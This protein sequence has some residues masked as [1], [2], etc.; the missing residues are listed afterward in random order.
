LANDVTLF[1]THQANMSTQWWDVTFVNHGAAACS[2]RG[3]PSL[4]FVQGAVRRPVGR[5]GHHFVD[6]QTRRMSLGLPAA[7]GARQSWP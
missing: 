2:L 3:D 5:P 4:Q 7:T 6:A 1:E